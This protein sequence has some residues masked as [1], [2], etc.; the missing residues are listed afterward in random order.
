LAFHNEE[1]ILAKLLCRLLFIVITT[2][3]SVQAVENLKTYIDIPYFNMLPNDTIDHAV[4]RFGKSTVISSPFAHDSVLYY[5]YG[6]KIALIFQIYKL[7]SKTIWAVK[8]I[9]EKEIQ[10]LYKLLSNSAENVKFNK[11]GK[12][13]LPQVLTKKGLKLGMT[14]RAVESILKTKLNLDKENQ[15]SLVWNEPK[16]GDYGSVNF[17]FIAG[18]LTSL[19]WYGVDP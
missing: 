15:A 6:H 8:F 14:Q 12:V 17:E 5:D 7:D 16:G 19:S 11:P 4:K 3:P 9:K 2:C 18:K 13:H 10:T 1:I